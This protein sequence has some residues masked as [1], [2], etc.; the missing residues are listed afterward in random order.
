[1]D[2]MSYEELF[3]LPDE[4]DEPV[5]SESRIEIAK[6]I[7]TVSVASLSY[8]DKRRTINTVGVAFAA[9][10]LKEQEQ[11]DQHRIYRLDNASILEDC[12]EVEL[13]GATVRIDVSEM[14]FSPSFDF[15]NGTLSSIEVFHREHHWASVGIVRDVTGDEEMMTIYI[16]TGRGGKQPHRVPRSA[17]V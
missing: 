3:D 10:W 1:M 7:P 16:E 13:N 15:I 17:C 12:T 11:W 4:I 2:A 9:A 14:R 6:E 8:A 5:P